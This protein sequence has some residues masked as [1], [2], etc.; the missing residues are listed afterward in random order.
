MSETLTIKDA[1]TRTAFT[2]IDGVRVAQ[3]TARIDSDDPNKMTISGIIKLDMDAY[4]VNRETCRADYAEFED[5]TY[6]L[7]ESY[8]NQVAD[9]AAE[10]EGE[11]E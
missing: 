1:I 6:D 4:K 9:Q 3:Y 10:S 2:T 7:Q 5:S 11:K 8:I